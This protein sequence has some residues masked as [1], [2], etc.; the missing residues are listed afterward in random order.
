MIAKEYFTVYN[1]CCHVADSKADR[2]PTNVPSPHWRGARTTIKCN[3]TMSSSGERGKEVTDGMI[4][5]GAHG[6]TILDASEDQWFPSVEPL[7]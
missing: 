4:A 6:G 5:V 7:L 1:K 3:W 2:W